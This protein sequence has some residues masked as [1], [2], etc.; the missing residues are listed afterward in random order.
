M[1]V[2]C[3]DTLLMKKGVTE[4]STTTCDK[5]IDI[6]TKKQCNDAVKLILNQTSGQ[7]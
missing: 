5:I 2:K 7:K 6:S 4:K 3:N 1:K